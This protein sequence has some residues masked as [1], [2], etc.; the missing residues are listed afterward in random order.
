MRGIPV[1][2]FCDAINGIATRIFLN[3]NEQFEFEIDVFVSNSKSFL[4]RASSLAR[5]GLH[6][7]VPLAA[8][9]DFRGSAIAVLSSD[10]ATT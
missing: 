10:N 5:I 1:R 6:G 8:T 4:P 2:L 3:S 7:P 9:A